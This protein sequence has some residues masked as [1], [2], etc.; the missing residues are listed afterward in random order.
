MRII[1]MD[2]GPIGGIVGG[3]LARGFLEDG[4]TLPSASTCPRIR[5][6]RSYR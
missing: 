3:W 5:A 1:V 6:S 4:A 2:E